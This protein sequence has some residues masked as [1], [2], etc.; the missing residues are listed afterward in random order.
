MKEQT[1][2]TVRKRRPYS[3][4]ALRKIDLFADEVLAQGCKSDTGSNFDNP[5]GCAAPS[6]CVAAGS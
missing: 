6:P 4:P 3:K 2:K 1:K 5:F